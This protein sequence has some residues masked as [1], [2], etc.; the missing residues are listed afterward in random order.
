MRMEG[1]HVENARGQ[2]RAG[3]NSGV[4][5]VSG[6]V[7]RCANTNTNWRPANVSCDTQLRHET[8]QEPITTPAQQVQEQRPCWHRFNARQTIEECARIRHVVVTWRRHMRE[9][10]V[11]SEKQIVSQQ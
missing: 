1:G 11:Q 10:I 9:E 8:V 3:K 2:R 6:H 4:G 7:Q 5:Y